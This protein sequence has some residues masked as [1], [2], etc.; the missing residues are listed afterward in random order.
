MH[1]RPKTRKIFENTKAT[2]NATSRLFIFRLTSS[3]PN[4]DNEKE[5]TSPFYIAFAISTSISIDIDII[6][7]NI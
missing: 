3:A 1:A 7:T 5:L 4:G 2:R 6:W